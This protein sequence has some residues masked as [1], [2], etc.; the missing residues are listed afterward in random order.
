MPLYSTSPVLSGWAGDSKYLP[1]ING[2]W[3]LFSLQLP[4]SCPVFGFVELYLSVYRLLS[5]Q[6]LEENATQISGKLSLLPSLLSGTLFRKFQLPQ[7]PQ[8]PIFVS[9]IQ[10]ISQVPSG[11]PSLC[12]S[13]EIASRQ[14][15]RAIAGRVHLVY[16]PSLGDHSPALPAGNCCLHSVQFSSY[17]SGRVCPVPLTA[18]WVDVTICTPSSGGFLLAPL[19]RLGSATISPGKPL[20]FHQFDLTPPSSASLCSPQLP[21]DCE[22]LRAW[23]IISQYLQSLTWRLEHN[24]CSINAH[25]LNG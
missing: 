16:V 24:R 8:A 5:S 17:Y 18:P 2:L 23:N 4:G 15:T 14:K 9:S 6:R 10:W 12:S 21:Q 11:F 19:L 13:A 22:L 7:S 1:A 3:E 20:D 25:W